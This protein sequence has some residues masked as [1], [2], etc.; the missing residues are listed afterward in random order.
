MRKKTKRITSR[1]GDETKKRAKGK[2]TRRRVGR[3][4]PER[5]E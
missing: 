2:R 3:A 1:R 4:G 5:E